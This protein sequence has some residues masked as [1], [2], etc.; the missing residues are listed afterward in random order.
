[1][2]PKGQRSQLAL[3]K[4]FTV[5][6]LVEISGG[7][8]KASTLMDYRAHPGIPFRGRLKIYWRLA[9]RNDPR[10]PEGMDVFGKADEEPSSEQLGT[11]LSAGPGEEPSNE[12]PRPT[13]Y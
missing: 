3:F 4:Y 2:A 6:E 5:D 8:Y 13:F 7:F 11:D 10:L 9:L 12:Q 1:M